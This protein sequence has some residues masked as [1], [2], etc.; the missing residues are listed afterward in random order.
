MSTVFR[1]ALIIV[2]VLTCAYVFRKIR[3]S[4]MRIEDTIFWIIFCLGVVVLSIFPQIATIM[5]G[6]LGMEAPVNFVFLAFI[7]ILIIKIFMM[8]VKI[9]QLEDKLGNIAQRH[10]LDNHDLQKKVAECKQVTSNIM[11]NNAGVKDGTGIIT[12]EN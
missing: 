3:K 10:E 12:E 2:S 1:I 5:T 11:D 9:S 7:F 8:S 4:Q 6:L